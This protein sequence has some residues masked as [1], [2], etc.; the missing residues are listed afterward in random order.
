MTE[1]D[2]REKV[3]RCASS[4]ISERGYE[5]YF[6]GTV[7]RPG[8][9]VEW[10]GIFCLHVLQEAGLA[11]DW[12]WIYGR[13]FLF[14]LPRIATP[15]PGDIAYFNAPHQHHALVKENAG[16]AFVTVDG[17]QHSELVSERARNF[18]KDIAFYSI[19]S[20]IVPLLQSTPVSE[21]L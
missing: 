15:L 16:G 7:H 19:K 5:Q 17:N 1:S 8:T 10:C 3:V 2:V 20:L 4:H 13:G 21:I 9:R 6:E 11:L 14:R 12:R 18:S